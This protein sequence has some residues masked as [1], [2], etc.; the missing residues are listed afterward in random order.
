M[1]PPTVI[2]FL[3]VLLGAD[4]VDVFCR[5]CQ[6]LKH[7]KGTAQV[8]FV[9]GGTFL[10]A[11]LFDDSSNCVDMLVQYYFDNYFKRIWP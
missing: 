9:G 8:D 5:L 6:A 2:D 10:G 1:I 4:G 11:N 3:D 7:E